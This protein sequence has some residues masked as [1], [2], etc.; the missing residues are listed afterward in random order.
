LLLHLEYRNK[1]SNFC[2]VWNKISELPVDL[3][4]IAA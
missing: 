2:S 3:P 4:G 1:T